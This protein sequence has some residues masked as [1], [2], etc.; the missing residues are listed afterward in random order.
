M[1]K[2]TS[3]LLGIL[4]T[5]IIGTILYWFFCCKPC[6]EAIQATIET[7][8][9]EAEVPKV[10]TA[11]KN[12]FSAIDLKSNLKFAYN[13][14][15]NFKKKTKDQEKLIE[16]QAK[17]LDAKKVDTKKIE[18]L[19]LNL[20][21]GQKCANNIKNI[22]KKSFKVGSPEYRACVLNKGKK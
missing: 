20:L 18:F 11:T 16:N 2:K 15:F 19:E 12:A 21:Y 5:I 6:L 1:S 9:M 3:Y 10:K 14:N 13:E 4:L 22:F 17:A 7:K 8:E